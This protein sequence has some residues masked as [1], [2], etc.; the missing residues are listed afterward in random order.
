RALT[1]TAIL[2]GRKATIPAQL[3]LMSD[4]KLPSLMTTV[5]KQNDY[6]T[7]SGYGFGHGLGY[8]KWGGVVIAKVRKSPFGRILAFYY[9]GTALAKA[10]Q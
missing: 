4:L 6:I 2:K 10:W 8:S 3:L 5:K 1:L 7:F 9:P